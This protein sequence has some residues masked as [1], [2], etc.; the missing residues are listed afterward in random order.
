MPQQLSPKK[1]IETQAR[2]LPIHKCLVNEDWEENQMANV[3]VMR[4]HVNGNITVG[5]YLVDL[6]CLGIKDT[7]YKFNIPEY[8]VDEMLGE[9]DLFTVTDYNLAHNIVFAGHD[10]AMEF[11]IPPHKD[12]TLTKNILAE[13]ND[14]IPL[15]E[16]AVGHR[17]DGKPHL[18]INAQGQGK[19]ALEKLIKNA[20]EGNYYYTA[21]DDNDEDYAESRTML[22]ADYRMGSISACA[23]KDISTEELLDKNKL[24]SREGFEI[25][26]LSIEC[27]I[28]VFEADE[29]YE[30]MQ[31]HEFIETA[32]FELNENCDTDQINSR[33]KQIY[34]DDLDED[35]FIEE[36]IKKIIEI[37]DEAELAPS[38]EKFII[39]Y[40][41]NFYAIT[42]S[43]KLVVMHNGEF[44]AVRKKIYIA[45]NR[46]I[47]IYP[48]AKLYL[49]FESVY[50]NAPDLRFANIQY[51]IDIQSCFPQY[52]TFG[53]LE[54]QLY[55]LI[56]MLKNIK[57][58]KLE[59]T[60]FY[61]QLAVDTL[62]ENEFLIQAQMKIL[63]YFNTKA[64]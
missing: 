36:D 1:Y 26:N 53:G 3:V 56:K 45:L 28:R 49:T 32:E 18:I 22:I 25:L 14:N 43:Y 19:W 9:D 42:A 20:G 57:D 16:I 23:A 15:I 59:K 37:R 27:M 33:E 31:E 61:Y 30:V 64:C 29:D 48:L 54:L 60:I 55:W 24:T 44:E 6:L 2:K 35:G 10:F 62:Q 52:K 21:Q 4:R 50:N 8:E 7:L 17:L 34:L 13:D 41:E 5:L 12:F 51:S 47:E 46:F 11:D 40:A 38:I 63:E 58:D 39:K